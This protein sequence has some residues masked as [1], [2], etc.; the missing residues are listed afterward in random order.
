MGCLTHFWWMRL[1]VPVT[2]IAYRIGVTR[3]ALINAVHFFCPLWKVSKRQRHFI[4]CLYNGDC[5]I[6]YLCVPLQLECDGP[7]LLGEGSVSPHHR[8]SRRPLQNHVA[9]V[10]I[11]KLELVRWV[12]CKEMAKLI[13][14][15][16]YLVLM[17]SLTHRLLLAQR[18]GKGKVMQWGLKH[19]W[20]SVL[21]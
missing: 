15:F 7:V 20:P 13:E 6:L 3:I 5:V 14:W 19:G 18:K 10:E 1:F 11:G 4:T 8:P 12:G 16:R 2:L 17:L 9:A 21:A